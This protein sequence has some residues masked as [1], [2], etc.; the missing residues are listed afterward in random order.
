M[1]YFIGLS[2]L[3]RAAALTWSVVMWARLRDLRMG[4]LAALML[5]V[6][7]RQSLTL[8]DL[9]CPVEVVPTD[10]AALVAALCG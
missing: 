9:P 4:W 3:I 6:F 2:L 1:L 10:G 5:Y 7:G 8:A